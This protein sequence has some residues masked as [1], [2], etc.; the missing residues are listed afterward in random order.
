MCAALIA[1]GQSRPAKTLLLP[2]FENFIESLKVMTSSA[3]FLH[4]TVISRVW[5]SSSSSDVR[6][7]SLTKL[8]CKEYQIFDEGFEED[9]PSLVFVP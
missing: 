5:S 4:R 9:T 6:V 2:G 7:W 3:L 8:R 1:L